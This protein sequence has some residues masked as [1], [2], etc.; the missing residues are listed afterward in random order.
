MSHLTFAEMLEVI[1]GESSH[2]DH[3]KVCKLCLDRTALFAEFSSN[4]KRVSYVEETRS[5]DCLTYEEI[6]DI[7]EG[8]TKTEKGK[9]H[10]AECGGCY[11]DAAHYYA[12]SDAMKR[13]AN[14][15]Q[16]MAPRRYIEAAKGIQQPIRDTRFEPKKLSWLDRWVFAP[17]PVYATAALLFLVIWTAPASMTITKVSGGDSYTIY[18]KSTN[19]IPYLFFGDVGKVSETIEASMKAAPMK[20]EMHF[21]W[22]ELPGVDEYHFVLQ[23]ITD[24]APRTV[25]HL[26]TKKSFVKIPWKQI[27]DGK[28]YRWIAAG[29]LSQKSY[30]R[31]EALFTAAQK[32]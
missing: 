12:Q 29:G 26:S 9:A 25:V 10:L 18:N 11:K 27:E 1:N 13:E 7:V 20:R 31:G 3:L 23:D 5:N 30:F 17:F 19:D 4:A 14:E 2:T 8:I 24:L 16:G 15:S 21:S 6:A 32:R 28:K 22:N